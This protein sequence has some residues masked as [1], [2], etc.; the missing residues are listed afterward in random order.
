MGSKKC[1]AVFSGPKQSKKFHLG[2]CAL[3]TQ[4]LREGGRIVEISHYVKKNEN[5]FGVRA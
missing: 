2:R 4:V 1:Q 5:C 3:P